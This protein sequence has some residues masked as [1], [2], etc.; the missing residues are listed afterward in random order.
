MNSDND[1]LDLDWRRSKVLE[2]SSQGHSEREMA[3]ILQV[4]KTTA[5]KDLVCLRQQAQENIKT[6]IQER[7]PEEY[8]K[9]M[10]TIGRVIKKTWEIV[11]KTADERTRLQ[12]LVLIDQCNTHKMDMVTN[13][14]IITDALNYV[15]NKTKEELNSATDKELSKKQEGESEGSESKESEEPDYGEEEELEERQEKDTG[16]LEEE[17]E[18]NYKRYILR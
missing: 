10:Y 3:T 15:N 14:A 11:D 1:R 13:G 17:Q 4:G 18:K 7:M 6:H 2:L 12:A 16:E 9:G 5:H 8:Q